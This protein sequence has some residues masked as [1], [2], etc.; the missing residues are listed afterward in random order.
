MAPTMSR[1]ANQ[2]PMAEPNYS[3]AVLITCYNRKEKTTGFLHSLTRQQG[4]DT[5]NPDIYLLDDGSTDGTAEAVAANFPLVKIVAGTGSLF[6]AGGMRAIWSHAIAQ[7]HYDVFLLYNDDVVLTEGSLARLLQCY[8]GVSNKG[9]V[10]VG[11]TLSPLS[12]TMSYGGHALYN[13][14][15]AAYYALA[16]HQSATQHCHLG[17]ANVFLVDT[18]AVKKIGIFCDAYTHYLADYDY[19]LTAFKAG[20]DVLVAPGYYGYCED[21][22][23]VNWL[24]GNT[25]LKKRIAYLYSPIGLAYKE[26]L[27]YIRKHFPA[28]YFGAVIK[29]WMKTLFPVIW[30][31]FKKTPIESSNIK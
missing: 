6:W 8:R 9:T 24:S 18:A 27:F 22:H 25:P 3:C 13:I 15:H 16:P 5:L 23:G 11:S 31:K 19:T 14:K 2:N 20:L 1:R 7:K 26:Y 29:L 12:N 21:D 28:D 17:N 10:L 4:F 30:D